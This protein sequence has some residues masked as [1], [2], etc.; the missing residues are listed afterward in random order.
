MRLRNPSEASGEVA[1][2][3]EAWAFSGVP[4]SESPGV[5]G[6]IVI[7]SL[8]GTSAEKTQKL[9][10]KFDQLLKRVVVR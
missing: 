2:N 1:K 4:A 9:A 6:R 3:E 7:K 8:A 10:I 5:A